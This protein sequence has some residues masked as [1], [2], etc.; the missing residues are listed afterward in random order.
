MDQLRQCILMAA[1]SGAIWMQSTAPSPKFFPDDPIQAMPAPLSIK[2]PLSSE[3]NDLYDFLVSSVRPDPRP[4]PAGA[5]NTLG[6]VPDS[7]WF[8]NRHGARRMTREQLQRGAGTGDA[9]APPFTIIG[10]KAEGITPGFRMKD[11]KGRK[12][13]VK[14]DPA[15]NPEMTTSTD[16]IVSK[17]FFA[18]GYNTPDNEI[19]CLKLADLLLASGV[20]LTLP[21][22]RSREMTWNDVHDMIEKVPH[23]SDGSFRIIASLGIEGKSIGA[24]RFEGVRSDDPN[25]IVPHENRRD[26][27][28]LYVFSAWVNNTDAKASNT[29]DTVVDEEGIRFIRHYLIDF[30]SALGSGGFAPKDPRLGHEFMLPSPSNALKSIL[31]LGLVPAEW[32]RARFPNLP[33]VGNFESQTFKPDEWKSD[34]PI[35]A[36]LSR[37]P[38]DDFWAARQVMAFTN[39]DIRAIV[40]TAKFSDHQATD[41]VTTN[42]AERR[43]KIG[44]EFFS[45]VLP[46]AHFR[47]ENEKLQFDD[48]A[49]NYGFRAPVKY[50][51]HWAHFDNLER[52]QDPIPDNASAELP[53]EVRRAPAGSYFSA[54]IESPG[55]RPKSV[56]VYL[57]K[58]ENA[59]KVVGAERTW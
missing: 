53:D 4:V 15:S 19:V 40:E 20:K 55:Q 33:A 7:E 29:L 36:F 23:Y 51:V 8:T 58:D 9:P 24:F 25:D 16:V 27:R 35:A 1:L 49:V 56:T 54:L 57:R 45:K 11:S 50:E 14:V 47:I 59:Y 46:L 41:Y 52:K 18:I 17:L 3:I 39:D 43:D 6:E 42:L 13:F 48:L 32:E 28:G 2:K 22:G 38:D 12:Y 44:R 21:D 5:I 34:Y 26:L 37:L 31:T 10:G 30:G